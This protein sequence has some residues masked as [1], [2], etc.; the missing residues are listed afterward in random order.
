MPSW[1]RPAK[2]FAAS[3]LLL[4]TLNWQEGGT[5]PNSRFAA[6]R[7]MAVDGRFEI[8]AYKDW[9]IDWAKPKNGHYYSNKAPGAALIAVPVAAVLEKIAPLNDLTTGPSRW[10]KFLLSWIFQIV[11]FLVIGVFLLEKAAEE[12]A[13]RTAEMF[14]AL[15][16]FFGNTA[17]YFMPTYFGHGLAAIFALLLYWALRTRN[18]SLA[19]LFFGWGLLTDYGFALLALP[20]VIIFFLQNRRTPRG[21]IMRKMLSVMLGGLFPGFLWVLYHTHCFGSP[22]SI[23]QNYQ[24]PVFLKEGGQSGSLS[25]V[26]EVFP[27]PTVVLQLLFGSKRGILFTQPWMLLVIPIGIFSRSVRIPMELRWLGILGFFELLWMNASFSGWH[28]GGSAGPR[29]M[30]LVFPL[31]ALMAIYVYDAQK[32]W[33]RRTLWVMVLCSTVLGGLIYS[34]EIMASEVIP[35]WTFYLK[36]LSIKFP[37]ASWA[38]FLGFLGI[39]LIAK[40]MIPR[41]GPSIS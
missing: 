28:G 11:P 15:A 31:I 9:T 25:S 1:K 8:D 38:A 20:S 29:Y 34:G 2:V 37:S 33:V 12:G 36:P 40:R 21:R 27:S 35:L 4:F 13:S 41:D 16:L 23:S 32:P 19:G 22:F 3:F 18:Y 24:N 7:A 14:A 30:C 6:M 39:L 26:I 17:S 10:Y 5:N